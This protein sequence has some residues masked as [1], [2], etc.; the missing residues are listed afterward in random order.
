[1]DIILQPEKV[2]KLLL[3]KI[4]QITFWT[5]EK[6]KPENF[7]WINLTLKLRKKLEDI[8]IYLHLGIYFWEN[9]DKNKV[10]FFIIEIYLE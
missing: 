10:E 3:Y 9:V 8:L 7:L 2:I 6:Y 5:G 1:M 4:K